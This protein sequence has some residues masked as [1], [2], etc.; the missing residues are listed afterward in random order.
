MN[1]NDKMFNTNSLFNKKSLLRFDSRRSQI[2]EAVLYIMKNHG[3]GAVTVRRVACRVGITCAALYRYYKSKTDLLMAILNHQ[4]LLINENFKKAQE[5]SNS[6]FDV[7]KKFYYYNMDVMS[8]Y[9]NLPIF[10]LFD[11][12]MPDDDHLQKVNNEYKY[13][14][15]NLIIGMI[16]K[17]QLAGEIRQDIGANEL[18]A[19]YF[20]L[21]TMPALIRFNCQQNMDLSK[22]I[23]ANWMLFT[24]AVSR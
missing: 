11:V 16:S 7:L 10:I 12:V 18:F 22:Q 19:L 9:K 21:I 20:G 4:F 17:A 23:D 1:C 6:P 15:R 13:S 14:L 24:C 2:A 3:V 8:L 5:L